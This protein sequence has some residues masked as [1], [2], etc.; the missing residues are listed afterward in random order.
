MEGLQHA[1]RVT[2]HGTNRWCGMWERLDLER[3]ECRVLLMRRQ[4]CNAPAI[5]P[6]PLTLILLGAVSR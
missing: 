4:T 2:S 5:V 6:L 1:Y 3:E